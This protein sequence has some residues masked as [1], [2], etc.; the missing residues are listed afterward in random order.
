MALII[1]TEQLQSYLKIDLTNQIESLTPF[2]EDAEKDYIRPIL[3]DALFDALD[4]YVNAEAP[5]TNEDYEALLPYVRNA[6]AK[7]VFLLGG[8]SLDIR[9]SE[10]GF[11][12]T[13]NS[14]F[15]PAS[16]E[17]VANLMDSVREL[18]WKRIE[19]LQKFLF[20]NK[21]DYDEYTA[22]TAYTKA[23][24]LFINYASD[25]QDQGVYINNSRY[26]FE[27]MRGEMQNIEN[28]I[29]EPLISKAQADAIKEEALADDLSEANAL[30][31]PLIRKAI[32]NIAAYKSD[33]GEKHRVLGDNYLAEIR[34]IIEATPEDYPEYEASDS[35][36]DGKT[37]N[38]YQNAEA[39]TS[40]TFGHPTN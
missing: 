30:I 36:E 34:K 29:I 40:F 22:S 23:I 31:Y 16:K 11:V 21:A 3:G 8:P 39:N 20:T 1:T 15:A 37:T 12:V 14:N 4:E 7:F 38:F 19:D 5:T 32:A 26:K 35:Y 2:I 25:F 10:A 17:R 28:L 24:A 18:G 9:I 33:M 27:L 13:M 6:L